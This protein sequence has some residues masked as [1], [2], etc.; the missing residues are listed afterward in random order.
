MEK[1]NT[2]CH[3]HEATV[4]NFV[5][6]AN[7][8]AQL[9][10]IQPTILRP[11]R[12][13][14]TSTHWSTFNLLGWR[15]STTSPSVMSAKRAFVLTLPPL[16]RSHHHYK[17]HTHPTTQRTSRYTIHLLCAAGA[18]SIRS[19]AAWPQLLPYTLTTQSL[20]QIGALACSS[21]PTDGRRWEVCNSSVANTS[22]ECNFAQCVSTED[23]STV[24]STYNWMDFFATQVR[25]IV[26]IRKF[27]HFRMSSSSLGNVFA[28]NAVIW[29]KSYSNYRR[30]HGL[31]MLQS[32]P[33]SFTTWAKCR[34]TVVFVLLH[35]TVLPRFQQ[36]HSLPTAIKWLW[37][38]GRWFSF[39][40]QQ[41][42]TDMWRLWTGRSWQVVMARQVTLYIYIQI[43]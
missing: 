14:H 24:V 29:Q 28:L 7:K 34:S 26:G 12:Q 6:N 30:N 19:T 5:G 21:A 20:H 40:T 13:L 38:H 43:L 41:A 32:C 17:A 22:A 39:T 3:R 23:G 33:L 11:A 18:L 37:L 2:I 10:Y 25:K 1:V 35:L 42:Q 15:G 27:H 16:T 9:L 8:T 4:R 36:R 31:Q